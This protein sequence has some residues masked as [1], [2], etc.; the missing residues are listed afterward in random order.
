MRPKK[1]GKPV[2]WIVTEICGFAAVSI[3]GDGLN[4]RGLSRDQVLRRNRL[5]LPVGGS[6]SAGSCRGLANIGSR[7]RSVE[8]EVY[9]EEANILAPARAAASAA[10]CASP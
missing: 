6:I 4:R 2:R 1:V 10:R 3:A 9:P 5:R 7:Q 8:A